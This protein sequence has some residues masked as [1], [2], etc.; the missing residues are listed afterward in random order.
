MVILRKK[1]KIKFI[2]KIDLKKCSSELKNIK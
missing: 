2:L 1:F